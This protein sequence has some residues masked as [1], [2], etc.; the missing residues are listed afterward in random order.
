[1]LEH[2]QE[3]VEQHHDSGND[4]REP[5]AG[6]AVDRRVQQPGGRQAEQVLERDRDGQVGADRMDGPE[7][8]R[9]ADRPD[10]RAAPVGGG[11]IGAGVV[12]AQEGRPPGDEEPQPDGEA[13]RENRS[14]EYS[15][16][17]PHTRRQS[18]GLHLRNESIPNRRL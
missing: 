14:H 7:E 1:V 4:R 9:I 6:G 3:T 5:R 18:N 15:H 17:Q 10:W 2:D 16:R 8:D 12:E 13:D 11:D